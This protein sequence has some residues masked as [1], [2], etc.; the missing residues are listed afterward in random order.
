LSG[1]TVVVATHDTSL[2]DVADRVVRLEDGRIVN[3]Q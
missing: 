3:S 1:T 2:N